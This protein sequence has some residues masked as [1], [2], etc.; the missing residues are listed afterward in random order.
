MPTNLGNYNS[1]N[2]ICAC[3][4]HLSLQ[5]WRLEKRISRLNNSE[6]VLGISETLAFFC[7][8]PNNESAIFTLKIEFRDVIMDLR[9]TVVCINYII[10]AVYLIGIKWKFRLITTW[11]FITM[12]F[13]T[14]KKDHDKTHS[15]SVTGDWCLWFMFLLHNHI[16]KLIP[17]DS[18]WF[19]GYCEWTR[20]CIPRLLLDNAWHCH[21]Y[22]TL[23][24][25]IYITKY[26]FS[27][28]PELVHQ[29]DFFCRKI[30]FYASNYIRQ[31]DFES[32][33]SLNIKIGILKNV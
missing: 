14:W 18:I 23:L 12:C 30:Y 15:V 32:F 28:T 25:K 6:V 24:Q 5:V 4:L 19:N 31:H 3:V 21:F 8:L 9:V 27:V 29:L 16:I 17:W 2:H 11:I 20:R 10:I 22:T 1:N 13:A 26:N 33:K 7:K